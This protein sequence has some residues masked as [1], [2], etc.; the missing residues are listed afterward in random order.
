MNRSFLLIKVQ[1]VKR[2]LRAL[3]GRE[4]ESLPLL[5]ADN[6]FFQILLSW[7]FKTI[8]KLVEYILFAIMNPVLTKEFLD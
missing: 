2:K 3:H 4:L 5:I 8:Q 1:R 6:D 7:F